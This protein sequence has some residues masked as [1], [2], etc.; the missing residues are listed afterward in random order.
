MQSK[1]PDSQIVMQHASLTALDR[2]SHGERVGDCPQAGRAHANFGR[3]FHHSYRRFFA[4]QH[5]QHSSLRLRP[6]Q[7]RLGRYGYKWL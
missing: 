4:V 7:S 6:S 1:P 2:A 5:F 3:F